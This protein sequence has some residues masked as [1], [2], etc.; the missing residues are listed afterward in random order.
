M[1]RV[2]FFGRGGQGV[3][4]ASR[5]LGNA[6]I[7]EG[8]EV[9][10]APPYG[11]EVRGA[12]AVAYIRAGPEPILEWGA[13]QAFDIVVVTDDSLLAGGAAQVLDGVDRHTALLI[14]SSEPAH[15]LRHRLGVEGPVFVLP[16]GRPSL[17]TSVTLAGGAARWLGVLRRGSLQEG[18]AKALASWGD[19]TV[20]EARQSV[21]KGYDALAT[22]TPLAARDAAAVPR[23]TESDTAFAGGAETVSSS[24]LKPQPRA[25]RPQVDTGRCNSCTWVCSSLCADAAIRL[26]DAGRPCVDL[27]LCRGCGMCAVRCPQ[28]AIDLYLETS[29]EGDEAVEAP[30]AAEA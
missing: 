28:G 1:F 15:A 25:I 7:R 12:P 22:A 8:Y 11:A 3:K 16:L 10:D 30:L 21:L 26:D 20:K 9:Q 4:A 24:V 6:F 23:R 19:E 18:V 2:Q 13:V 17:S 14:A 27:A 5:V 29:F